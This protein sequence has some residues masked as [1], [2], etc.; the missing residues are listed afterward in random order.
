MV[1]Q[2][3]TL[4]SKQVA[5]TFE[6]IFVEKLDIRPST[7][8]LNKNVHTDIGLDSLDCMEVIMEMEKRFDI[9][10]LDEETLFHVSLGT[11]LNTCVDNLRRQRRLSILDAWRVRTNFANLVGQNLSQVAQNQK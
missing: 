8:G 6:N 4:N 3:I 9:Q 11:M 5:Q 10:I 1:Q 2:K 7:F